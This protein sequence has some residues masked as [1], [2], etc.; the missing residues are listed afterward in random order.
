MSSRSKPA[1][2]M[3]LRWCNGGPW[4]PNGPTKQYPGE[5]AF[6]EAED[7]GLL[8]HDPI[9]QLTDAGRRALAASQVKVEE[10][11]ARHA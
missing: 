6:Y 5:H 8:A 2:L 9:W 7:A 11:I 1:V 3:A 4:F 10:E